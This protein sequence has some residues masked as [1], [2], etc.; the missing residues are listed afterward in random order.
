VDDR[1]EAVAGVADVEQLSGQPAG[2]PREPPTDTLGQSAAGQ[3]S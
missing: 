1:D 3:A 2:G